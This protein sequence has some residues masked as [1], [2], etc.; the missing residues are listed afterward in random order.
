MNTATLTLNRDQIN[1]IL[2]SV[3]DSINWF[4]YCSQGIDL[5]DDLNDRLNQFLQ[6]DEIFSDAKKELI[7][8]EMKGAQK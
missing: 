4:R 2:V 8:A 6:I 1:T 3:R 5:S 7:R